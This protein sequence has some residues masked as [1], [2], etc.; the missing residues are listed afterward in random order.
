MSAYFADINEVISLTEKYFNISGDA[1]KYLCY[2]AVR[3]TFSRQHKKYMPYTLQMQNALV[4]LDRCF[5]VVWERIIFGQERDYLLSHGIILEDV[6]DNVVLKVGDTCTQENKDLEWT[7]VTH[8][9]YKKNDH[10]L[11]QIGIFV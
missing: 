4:L 11:V 7:V 5:G 3:S 9:K 1:A 6:K 2:R 8:K 10:A